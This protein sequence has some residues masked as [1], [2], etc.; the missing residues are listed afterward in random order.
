MS[1]SLLALTL[2][3]FA[4][5]RQAHAFPDCA[6][7]PA[8]TACQSPTDETIPTP[9]FPNKEFNFTEWTE[10]PQGDFGFITVRVLAHPYPSGPVVVGVGTLFCTACISNGGYDVY[11]FDYSDAAYY[12]NNG[13][14]QSIYW[15]RSVY[16]FVGGHIMPCLR[17]N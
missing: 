16:C 13:G 17:E 9:E 7:A 6:T 2:T 8:N 5:P 11:F 1:V 12:L 15:N 10:P 14:F 4:V 3:L